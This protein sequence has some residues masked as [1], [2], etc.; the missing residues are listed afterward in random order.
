MRHDIERE[1]ELQQGSWGER[2]VAETLWKE[3][4]SKCEVR[5]GEGES[6]RETVGIFVC[7]RG[8]K[9][10]CQVWWNKSCMSICSEDTSSPANLN[11]DCLIRKVI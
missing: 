5:K 3:H 1:T 2:K 8:E 9:R 4:G 10:D 7:V 11:N 6:V